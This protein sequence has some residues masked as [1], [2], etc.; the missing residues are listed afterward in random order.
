VSAV[1]ARQS[2]E[3]IV[4]SVRAAF[5]EVPVLLC[6]SRAAGTSTTAS[7]YDLLIAM[8]RRRIPFA[9]RRLGALAATLTDELAAPV[10]V[11]P[12]PLGLLR[13]RPNL[14]VWKLERE[15]L[16]LSPERG[17]K[18]PAAGEPPLDDNARFSYLMT[19]LLQLLSVADHADDRQQR[20][21][22]KALLHVAQL[23]LWEQ[24]TYPQTLEEA[25]PKLNDNA[26]TGPASKAD[27]LEGWRETRSLVVGELV[28]LGPPRNLIKALRTNARYAVLAALRG[29]LRLWAVTTLR[30]IDRQLADV[31]V[32]LALAVD[33]PPSASWTALRDRV[34]AEW[35]DAHP[36]LAQ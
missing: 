11:N 17:F 25:L 20:A 26:L 21:V 14:F 12:L 29:R 5:G 8:P 30:P 24:G 10:S 34:L 7:D 35:P 23:R 3:V 31:A 19:A 6:G 15:A 18:L 16:V 28:A 32:E 22:R 9:L 36:L 13:R 33:G 4:T 2:E 27:S 1:A